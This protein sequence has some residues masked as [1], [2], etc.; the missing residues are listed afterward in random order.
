MYSIPEVTY[1]GSTEVEFMQNSIPYEGGIARYQK[2][3]LSQ[4][5]GDFPTACARLLSTEDFKLLNMHIFG[6]SATE[7]GAH[8]AGRDGVWGSTVE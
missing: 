2:L 7:Y 8:R 3:V 4:I 6:T 5:A 1:V